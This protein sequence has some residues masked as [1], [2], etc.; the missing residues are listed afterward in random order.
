MCGQKKGLH[1]GAE[2]YAIEHGRHDNAHHLSLVHRPVS[3]DS[4][5][6]SSNVRN[7]GFVSRSGHL[8]ACRSERT[9]ASFAVRPAFASAPGG[10]CSFLSRASTSSESHSGLPR[11]FGEPSTSGFSWRFK[12]FHPSVH[13]TEDGPY[14]LIDEVV[15]VGNQFVKRLRAHLVDAVVVGRCVI[16]PVQV[17]QV[18]G[19][20]P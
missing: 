4:F 1:Y 19:T 18:S 17:N 13:A 12:R 16:A 20:D 3:T 8:P 7:A 10:H 9:R 6:L 5:R 2:A 14:P 15:D 11:R